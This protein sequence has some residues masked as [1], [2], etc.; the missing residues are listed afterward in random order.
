MTDNWTKAQTIA[1]FVGLGAILI[2]FFALLVD[3]VRNVHKKD[4]NLKATDPAK[5][6]YF[7]IPRLGRWKTLT[8]HTTPVLQVTS[9]TGLIEAGD[10]GFW[11]STALDRIPAGHSDITWIP[12]FASIFEE[13]WHSKVDVPKKWGDFYNN[14]M[15]RIKTEV[16]N[17]RIP[18]KSKRWN[19]YDEGRLVDCCRPLDRKPSVGTEIG[20]EETSAG[21]SRSGLGHIRST[22]TISQKPCVETTREELIALALIIGASIKIHGYTDSLNGV[23]AFGLSLYAQPHKGSWSLGLTQ[24]ARIQ[25]HIATMGSGYTTLMAKHL[26]CGSIP[27]S[28]NAGWVKSIYL[29]KAVYEAILRGKNIKDISAYGG[30]SMELLRMLPAEKGVDAYYG[31]VDENDKTDDMGSGLVLR[32]KEAQPGWEVVGNWPRAVTGIAFGGLVP[33]VYPTIAKAV[34]F[35]TWGSEGGGNGRL[36]E[37]LEQLVDALHGVEHNRNP[38]V[39]RH[40]TE[41]PDG[42]HGE[43]CERC[44]FG[45]YVRT[46][47]NARRLVDYVNYV[48]P[49]EHS[50]PRAAASVFARYS[51]LLERVVALCDFG[52]HPIAATNGAPTTAGQNAT[53][54]RSRLRE[55]LSH[56]RPNSQSAPGTSQT[57]GPKRPPDNAVNQ[58]FEKT[59]E[60]LQ[61]SYIAKIDK[62]TSTA[63]DPLSDFVHTPDLGATLGRITSSKIT[64][65]IW[66]HENPPLTLEEGAF[67]IRCILAAWS[68]QVPHIDL[69]GTEVRDM[70]REKSEETREE[71]N[72]EKRGRIATLDE[73]PP[74]L[75]FG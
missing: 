28:Q 55:S 73:L 43:E 13:V 54:V 46:R 50:S 72:V 24:G 51:N 59:Y 35:T 23:G 64:D 5:M 49:W 12:L 75:V 36:V 16:D 9:I 15:N 48:V 21:Q 19:H 33:Q 7:Y 69:V 61:A 56:S 53:S 47:Y 40:A 3:R 70:E 2:G 11:T 17:N 29:N 41:L 60:L 22:W 31:V 34:Q 20:P 44:I 42:E 10:R 62:T 71:G 68:W 14:V 58:I 38:K 18:H 65:Q 52:G 27:F 1:T 39:T 57:G 67:I 66:V 25:R 26:A 63:S 8:G 32:P 6:R 4:D 74:V 45:Q 30:Q 37:Q